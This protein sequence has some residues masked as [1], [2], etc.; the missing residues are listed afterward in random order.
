MS[1]A[2]SG[3]AGDDGPVRGRKDE[4]SPNEPV[5]RTARTGMLTVV[6]LLYCRRR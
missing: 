4:K 3:Y 6:M 2:A 5:H 1:L